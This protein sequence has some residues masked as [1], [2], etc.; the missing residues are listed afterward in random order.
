MTTTAV[1]PMVSHRSRFVV[2]GFSSF[3]KIVFSMQHFFC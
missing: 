2:I 3:M 1:P